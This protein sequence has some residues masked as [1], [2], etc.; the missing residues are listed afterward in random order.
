MYILESTK[1]P[2][3]ENLLTKYVTMN[4]SREETLI[5]NIKL[6]IIFGS[7]R[8]VHKAMLLVLDDGKWFSCIKS[9]SFIS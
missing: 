4:A 7:H 8:N 1:I 5:S 9:I 6:E 2:F 3:V